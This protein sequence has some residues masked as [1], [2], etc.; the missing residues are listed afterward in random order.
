MLAEY[1]LYMRNK[2]IFIFYERKIFYEK[3]TESP[4][5]YPRREE[6]RI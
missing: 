1:Q 4:I 5:R 2:F 3:I 6:N